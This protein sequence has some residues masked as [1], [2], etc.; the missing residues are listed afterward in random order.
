MAAARSPSSVKDAGNLRSLG[1]WPHHSRMIRFVICAALTLMASACTDS[2]GTGNVV[3]SLI[4]P[5]CSEDGALRV[6]CSADVPSGEC[7]AF[8]L[9]VDFF[10][11]ES[12]G[13]GALVRLQRGGRNLSLTDGL[14][15]EVGDV[16]ALRGTLG[17]I[18]AVGPDQNIRASL[19][20]FDRCP[21]STQ[22]FLVTGVVRFDTFGLNQDNTIS[23][24]IQRLEVRDAR[25]E[26]GVGEVL[27][28]LHGAFE[29]TVRKGPPYEQFSG[30]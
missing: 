19:A 9:G 21:D 25:P 17:E 23:G 29:F 3:G 24:V 13:K 10:S 30:G 27:G 28:V 7:T 5:D 8:S 6:V 14:I 15:L 26:R 1:W 4:V 2:A 11:A 18:Q 12:T 20:L 22:S 16:R